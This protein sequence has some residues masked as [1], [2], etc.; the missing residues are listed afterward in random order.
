MPRSPTQTATGALGY[1]PIVD[2]HHNPSDTTLK[3]RLE[4]ETVVSTTFH[5]FWRPGRGWAMARDLN[6][7]DVIRTLAGRTEVLAVEPGPD[8]PVFN[9]NV[10]RK[11]TFFVGSQK[12]LVHDNSLP[13]PVLTLFD[14]EP[15]LASVAEEAHMV[16][17]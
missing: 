6:A 9:L 7:G 4:A 8:Q 10:A 16:R 12:E 14:V 3:I 17:Q 13:P 15:S 11:C 2:V 1:E 5:R